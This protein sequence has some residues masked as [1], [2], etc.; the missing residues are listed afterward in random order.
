MKAGLKSLVLA[1]RT[2]HRE[3]SSEK[4]LELLIDNDRL[5]NRI[6][7]ARREYRFCKK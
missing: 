7:R 5:S 3:L 2:E 1:M 4:R 6:K